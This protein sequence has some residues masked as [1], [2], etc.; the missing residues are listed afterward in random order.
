MTV[1]SFERPLGIYI[2]ICR[3]T[4]L[5]WDLRTQNSSRVEREMSY[6]TASLEKRP[7]CLQSSEEGKMDMEAD[8]VTCFS[9]GNRIERDWIIGREAYTYCR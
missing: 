4:N 1:G 8:F 2:Y 6:S 7:Y 3:H 9:G 5:I